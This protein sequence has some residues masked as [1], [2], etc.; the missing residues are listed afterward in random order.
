MIIDIH[1]LAPDSTHWVAE[2]APIA[3]DI[4]VF[5]EVRELLTRSTI[6]TIVW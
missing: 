3:E 6:Y 2:I 5:V 1:G 4:L